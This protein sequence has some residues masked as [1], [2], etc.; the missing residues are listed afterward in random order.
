MLR[1]IR[2]RATIRNRYDQAPHLT[3][4][5]N[6]K[7]TATQLDII[8]ES[9]EVSPFP[10]GDHKA[11]INRRERKITKKQDRNDINDPQKKQYFREF[12]EGSP[13]DPRM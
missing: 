12:S 11:S 6:G 3:Q 10:G 5:T 8:N 7:V 13:L 4:D 9:Q 1:K 2:M